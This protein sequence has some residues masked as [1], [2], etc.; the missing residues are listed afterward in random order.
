M[1]GLLVKEKYSIWNSCKAF[2][3]IPVFFYTIMVVGA[4]LHKHDIEGFPVGMVFMMMGLMPATIVNQEMMSRWHVNVLTMPYTRE[5][6]VSAKYIASL[7]INAVTAVVTAIVVGVCI[8]FGNIEGSG[9]A[10]M[11]KLIFGGIGMGLLPAVVFLPANFKFYDT[12]GGARVMVSSLVGG[13]I[14]GSNIVIMESISRGHSILGG[15]FIFMC[16]MIV[17]FV[18]SW[19]LSIV[20]FRK[21]DV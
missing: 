21:K 15:G 4:V 14:G 17:L 16:L 12:V 19:W 1:K 2:L 10:L 6:I 3:I 20:F 8:A 7:I 9:A 11:A 18:I 5:Q 13:L